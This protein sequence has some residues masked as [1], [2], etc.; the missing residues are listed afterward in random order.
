MSGLAGWLS[1]EF[2]LVIRRR[3]SGEFLTIFI[4]ITDA[5]GDR[6]RKRDRS[7]EGETLATVMLTLAL[8]CICYG[9]IYFSLSSLYND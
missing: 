9:I 7:S 5:V 2:S 6:G 1:T 8:N 3:F 4:S